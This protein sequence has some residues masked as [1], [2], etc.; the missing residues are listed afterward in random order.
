MRPDF[1]S[2]PLY[3]VQVEH[4]GIDERVA[5]SYQ[6]AKLTMRAYGELLFSSSYDISLNCA[7]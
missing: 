5:L 6:R 7:S 3:Q 2:H 4:L 1:Y